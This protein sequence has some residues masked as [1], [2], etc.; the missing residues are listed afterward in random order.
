MQW[1]VCRKSSLHG[2]RS[3]ESISIEKCS[4]GCL[5]LPLHPPPPHN[6]NIATQRHVQWLSKCGQYLWCRWVLDLK[7]RFLGW[8]A[9]CGRKLPEQGAFRTGMQN[10][11]YSLNT[12]LEGRLPS[13]FQPWARLSSFVRKWQPKAEAQRLF[14]PFILHSLGYCQLIWRLPEGRRKKREEREVSAWF[15]LLLC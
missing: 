10:A 3:N 6:G 15:T 13:L 5:P 1:Q 2:Y 12:E 4:T 14:T 9:A 7:S 11:D 8:E